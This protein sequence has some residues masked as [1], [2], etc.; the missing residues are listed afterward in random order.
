[1]IVVTAMFMW[2]DVANAIHYVKKRW[3]VKQEVLVSL[4]HFSFI[5]LLPKDLNSRNGKRTS[6]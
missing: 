5:M 1:M 2:G 4:E 3:L 6:R